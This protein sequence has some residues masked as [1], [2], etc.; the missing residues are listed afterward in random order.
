MSR[1]PSE[2][3]PR[4]LL[5]CAR[6]LDPV[7]QTDAIADVLLV[8][9][10]IAAIAPHIESFPEATQVTEA[11]GAILAPALVDLYCHSSEPGHE[12]RGTL[13]ELSAAAA[14]GGFSRIAVLPQTE[15]PLDTPAALAHLHQTWPTTGPRLYAWAALTQGAAGEQMAE[16]GE[17][18]AANSIGFCDGRPL[19]NWNLTRR[20]LEYAQPWGKPLALVAGDRHLGGQGVAREGPQAVQ[21]GLP[22]VPVS[23]ETAAL[24]ALLELVAQTGTPIHLMRLSTARSVELVAEAKARGLPVTAS[25]TW[26]HLLRDTATLANYDPHLRLEPPLGNPSDRAALL[27]GVR[28]GTIDAIASDRAAYTYEEKMVAF[29]DAPPGALGLPLVL[30]LLWNELVATGQCSAL[31]LWRA[32]SSGPLRCL[33]QAP[34]HCAVGEPAELLLFDPQ[35]IWRVDSASLHSPCSNTSWLGATLLGR[36]QCLWLP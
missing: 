9:G 24:A 36:V 1:A 25:V 5:R 15:P 12:E 19:A 26:L 10:R 7:A 14:A 4:E 6:V 29:A 34:L 21:A 33:Q 17:L 32:L 3:P 11:A 31:E 23:A 13:A 35:A 18:A 16:L 8:E 20:L 30:P 22:G 27:E 2:A 28:Q